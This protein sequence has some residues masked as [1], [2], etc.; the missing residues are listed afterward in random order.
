MVKCSFCGSELRL[1]GGKMFIKRD[2]TVFYFC[3]NKCEK[4]QVVMNRKPLKTKWTEA[5]HKLK[6]TML[7]AKGKEKK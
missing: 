2:A 3:S 6:A 1:G 7:S 5:H 4:N